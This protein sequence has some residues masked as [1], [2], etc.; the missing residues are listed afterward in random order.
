MRSLIAILALLAMVLVGFQPAMAQSDG[1]DPWANPFDLEPEGDNPYG[2]NP[3]AD[4]EPEPEPAPTPAPAPQPAPTPQPAPQPTPRVEPA[5]STDN[6]PKRPDPVKTIPEPAPQ[7]APA[8]ASESAD[9]AEA[10]PYDNPYDSDPAPAGGNADNDSQ[11][12]NP[13]DAE[14][15]AN[16]GGGGGG[17]GGG[18]LGEDDLPPIIDETKGAGE[19][20]NKEALVNDGIYE[21]NLSKERQ[22]LKYDHLR[23]ADIFWQKRVWR[24]IDTDQKMNQVFAYP[25]KPLIEVLLDIIKKNPD[26]AEIFMTDAFTERVTLDELDKQLNSIDTILVTDPVTE[27]EFRKIIRNDFNWMD[28]KKFRV[29]EDWVFDEESSR[30]IVRIIAIAPILD[31]YDDYGNF[32]GVYPLFYAYYPTFRDHLVNYEVFNN[33]NDAQ[34]MS[35]EDLLEMRY[36]ASYIMKESNL[37]DRR[38]IDYA[39]GRDALLE[40]ERVKDQ[41]FNF[42]QNLWSY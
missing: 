4:P 3:Y 2:D 5:P 6:T 17:G 42:E 16:S 18:G 26:Q 13:Y 36:F 15:T 39:Q 30:M 11:N 29:K 33:G 7:P 10:N 27:K 31:K 19:D 21:K 37:Q 32:L 41:I 38:I 14:D 28:V 34:R 8:P 25:K 9:D 35:W 20:Q 12:Q 24:V 23:E 1:D 22:V 40:S